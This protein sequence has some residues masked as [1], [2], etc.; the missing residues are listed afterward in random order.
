MVAGP[1]SSSLTY[2][3]LH[4]QRAVDWR[5]ENFSPLFV[6]F[7]SRLGYPAPGASGSRFFPRD[8]FVL[9][10]ISLCAIPH[11]TQQLIYT[12]RHRTDRDSRDV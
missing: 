10:V 2:D 8:R 7:S 6:L 1:E 11:I 3:N 4:L 12:R 5:C 9:A